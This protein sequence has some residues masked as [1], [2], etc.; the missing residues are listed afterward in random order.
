MTNGLF[1]YFAIYGQYEERQRPERRSKGLLI[2]AQVAGAPRTVTLVLPHMHS[3]SAIDF[4]ASTILT[5]LVD[6]YIH[7][8]LDTTVNQM[9]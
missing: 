2:K 4:G 9:A 6:K 3:R 7:Q 8:L 1:V 5:E